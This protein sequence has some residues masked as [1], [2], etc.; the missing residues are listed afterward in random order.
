MMEGGREE[1][2]PHPG[3]L[4][5]SWH[6]VLAYWQW[7]DRLAI[8]S[9]SSSPALQFTQLIE[10]SEVTQRLCNGQSYRLEWR[11][12]LR[13]QL[14]TMWHHSCELVDEDEWTLQLCVLDHLVDKVVS[15]REV[16]G[17]LLPHVEVTTVLLQH[18]FP[19]KSSC[20]W[21][22]DALGTRIA[23]WLATQRTAP[24]QV[25]LIVEG[26]LMALYQHQDMQRRRAGG[27]S[28]DSK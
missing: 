12:A 4:P 25:A 16:N 10:S 9:I 3:M 15:S 7:Y 26:W 11:H 1:D 5:P 14:G 20:P 21:Q 22:A 28:V 24:R 23:T 13:G 6:D 27:S 17:L 8:R 2:H 19:H 18:F